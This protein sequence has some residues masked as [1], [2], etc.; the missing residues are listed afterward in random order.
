MEKKNGE[1]KNGEKTRDEQRKIY[2]A[3]KR[4]I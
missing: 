3:L 2:L 4:H 1:R